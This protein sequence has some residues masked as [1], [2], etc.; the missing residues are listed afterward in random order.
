MEIGKLIQKIKM[1][2]GIQKGY[3][4]ELESPG[5]LPLCA[6]LFWYKSS[7]FDPL[8]LSELDRREKLMEKW[9]NRS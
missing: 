6:R 4:D 2:K 7:K 9:H 8:N 5:Y 3:Y 1:S